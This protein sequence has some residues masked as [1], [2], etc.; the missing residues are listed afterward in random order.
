MT[1]NWGIG[2]ENHIKVKRVND[3]LKSN[4][5]D[6]WFD[7][8]ELSGDLQKQMTEGVENSSVIVVFITEAYYQKVNYGTSLDNCRYEFKHAFNK[9]GS[10]CMIPIVMEASMRSQR[11]WSG[12]L[13]AALGSSLFIDFSEA[14]NDDAIFDQKMKELITRIAALS[15]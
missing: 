7:E 6:T 11:K 2:C 13:G 12:E 8:Q 10:E 9:K 14:F 4:S 5:L 1:H 15:P 3:A